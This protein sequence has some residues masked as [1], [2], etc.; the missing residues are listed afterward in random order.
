MLG[1]FDTSTVG[2]V[3]APVA[4]SGGHAGLAANTRRARAAARCVLRPFEL[5]D[6]EC[7][8]MGVVVEVVRVLAGLVALHQLVDIF[9]FAM[10]AGAGAGSVRIVTGAA[11]FAALLVAIGFVTPLALVGL[12]VYFAYFPVVDNLG[13]QFSVI[14]F[15]GLLL[16]GAG[17]SRSVDAILARRSATLRLVVSGVYVLAAGH[18]RRNVA[19]VRFLL[20]FLFWGINVT[21]MFFHAADDFWWQGHVLQLAFTTPYLTDHYQV[22][23]AIRDA[24]PGAYVAFCCVALAV[25]AVWEILL[26]PLMY[27]RWTRPFVVAQGAGFFV[28]SLAFLNLQYLPVVELLLWSLLFGP[29]ALAFARR[30][31]RERLRAAPEVRPADLATTA[32]AGAF[33]SVNFGSR[34]LPALVVAGCVIAVAQSASS[35]SI[36]PYSLGM[37]TEPWYVRASAIFQAVAQRPVNVFNKADLAMGSAWFVLHE[38]DDSGRHLRLVPLYDAEGGRLDYLRNDLLYFGHSLKWQR[39]LPTRKFEGGDPALPT[40]ASVDL[41]TNVAHLDAVLTGPTR[42]RHYEARFFVREMKTDV[43]PVRW[44]D[45]VAGGRVRFQVRP[46]DVA[47]ARSADWCTFNLPPGQAGARDRERQTGEWLASNP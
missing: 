38:T 45:P 46:E 2:D 24:F 14:L 19:C 30:T 28:M 34:A 21:A 22:L 10:L 27:S 33:I 44:L 26:V 17:Q 8:E 20:M 15:W 5:G 4:G 3:P 36:L 42:P 31:A 43:L 16:F 11:G 1:N 25:Q 41:A 9:G 37:F 12:L 29:V 47:W 32:D 18:T 39:S 7:S 23:R 6:A 40:A 13:T 35:P